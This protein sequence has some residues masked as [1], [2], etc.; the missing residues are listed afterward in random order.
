MSSL[1]RVQMLKNFSL[2]EQWST[3]QPMLFLIFNIR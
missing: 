2:S 1:V 3:D